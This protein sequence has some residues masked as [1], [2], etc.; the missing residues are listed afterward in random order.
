MVASNIILPNIRKFLVPDPDYLIVDVDLSGADA[1]VVAWEAED[2]D[3]KAA[4]RAG[5]KIH[6]KNARDMFQSE[7]ADM[8]DEEI[9]KTDYPG[10]IYYTCKRTVHALNYFGTPKGVAP[11]VKLTVRKVENFQRKWFGLHPGIPRWHDRTLQHLEGSECWSCRAGMAIMERRCSTC[12]VAMG[13]TICNAFGYRRVYFERVG[14]PMLREA[15]AWVPQSTVAIITLRG[16]L[17]LEDTYPFIQMLLQVHDSLTFQIPMSEKSTL[18]EIRTTLNSITV[19]YPDP[20]NIQWGL[21]WSDQSWG[22]CR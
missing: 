14:D 8:T 19:P 5:V 6:L 4:F 1:Q 3:L 10:G 12:G 7:T 15:L 18:P 16:L 9:K 21:K 2:D 11:R 22:D 20:L 13:R 17:L